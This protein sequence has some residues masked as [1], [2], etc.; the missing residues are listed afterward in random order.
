[1]KLKWEYEKEES[2]FVRKDLFLH[3]NVRIE[4]D[5]KEKGMSGNFL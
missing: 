5:V 4:V 3:F 2:F 1:M